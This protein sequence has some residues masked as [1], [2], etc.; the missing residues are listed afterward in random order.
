MM[1]QVLVLVQK[2]VESKEIAIMDC[3]KGFVTKLTIKTAALYHI[4][5]LWQLTQL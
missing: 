2:I 1:K 5:R 3:G 4:S